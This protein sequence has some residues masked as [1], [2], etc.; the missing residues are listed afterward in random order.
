MIT[1]KVT[2]K[3]VVDPLRPDV[4]ALYLQL[5]TFSTIDQMKSP[6]NIDQLRGLISTMRRSSGIGAEYFD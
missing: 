5:G 4:E 2:D 3:D 6:L 1:M